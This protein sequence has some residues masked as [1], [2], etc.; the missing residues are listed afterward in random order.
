MDSPYQVEQA[1]DVDVHTGMEIVQGQSVIVRVVAS[2]T[3]Y[4]LGPWVIV[5]AYGTNV[6]KESTTEVVQDT[7]EEVELEELEELEG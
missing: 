2:V 3:V 4:V 1:T 7:D 5:V 6:V